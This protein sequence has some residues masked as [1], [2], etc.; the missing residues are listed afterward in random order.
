MFCS[1]R[2]WI[3]LSATLLL[4]ALL[5]IV[6]GDLRGREIS[7]NP[8]RHGD[9]RVTSSRLKESLFGMLGPDMNGQTFLDLC[10]GCGQIG[11]EAHS[12]GGRVTINEPHRKRSKLLKELVRDWRLRGVELVSA[13][14]QVLIPRFAEQGR[15]FDMIYLDT[16]YR[17]HLGATSLFLALVERLS[18]GA[19][20]NPGGLLAIQHPRD[21]ELEPDCGRLYMVRQRRY[22]DNHLSI[23]ATSDSSAAR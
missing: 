13:K 21:A 15:G 12:R 8:R 16:P 3:E 7:F 22:G 20:L 18:D 14:A 10:A 1:A 11:L 5:R 23:F 6:A 19:L 4:G 9:I 17:A 2:V